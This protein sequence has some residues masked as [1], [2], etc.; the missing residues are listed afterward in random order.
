MNFSI[1]GLPVQPSLPGPPVRLQVYYNGGTN[2][3][4]T[5]AYDYVSDE[6]SMLGSGHAYESSSYS[7]QPDTGSDTDGT[8]DEAYND[9]GNKDYAE[10]S[11][12]T[13]TYLYELAD[14]N[15]GTFGS[16]KG[17]LSWTTIQSMESNR[18]I[19]EK[20]G[21][22]TGFSDGEVYETETDSNGIR[23]FWTRADA[24]GGDSGGPHY[25]SDYNPDTGET[26]ISIAG[27]HSWS[28]GSNCPR[29]HA[30]APY[31][32]EAENDLNVEV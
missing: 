19:M 20:Q 2:T 8:V 28:W 7:Y 11:P 13:E 27:I 3:L 17:I 25:T 24:L 31:I 15:G 14:D 10:L 1:L 30:G 32:G 12:Y 6:L 26:E 9:D 23:A 5:P 29:T 16:I 18:T 4:A 22:S 21:R